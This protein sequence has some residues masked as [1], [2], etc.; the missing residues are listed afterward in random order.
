MG[1][2]SIAPCK[3]GGLRHPLALNERLCR[4]NPHGH[5]LGKGERL[6][7]ASFRRCMVQQNSTKT[8]THSMRHE[9]DDQSVEAKR[10]PLPFLKQLTTSNPKAA[11]SRPAAFFLISDYQTPAW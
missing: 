8:L 5:A 2:T 7:I 4:N 1:A 11:G 9:F 3:T 10:A 6:M